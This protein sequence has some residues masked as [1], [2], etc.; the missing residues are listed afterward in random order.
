MEFAF[1]ARG[2]KGREKA[3]QRFFEILPG[4]TSWSILAGMVW[5]SFRD[6][7]TAAIVIIAFDFHWLLR[8]LYTTLFLVLAYVRLAIERHTDWLLRIKG[9]DDLARSAPPAL[10]PD[11]G[12][13]ERLSARAH[14]NQLERLKR[15]GPPPP[16]SRAVHHLV[17]FP[18][19]NEAREILEPGVRSVV[20]QKFPLK[21]VMLVVAL[22]A[23][24]TADVKAGVYA[25][26]EQ[27]GKFLDFQVIEHPDGLP[28]EARVKGA[29]A[30]FAARRAA[31]LFDAKGVPYENVVAS[32]LDAD[33][34]VSPDYFSCLTYH[35]LV[36]PDRTRASYQPI[37]VYHNNIWD[38][39][40]FARVMEMG[41]SFFQLMEATNPEK[42]VT[43]SSHSMSFKALV[44]TGYWPVDMI[45]DD[46]AIFW[47]AY[48]KFDGKY[49]VV[50]MYVTLSM[51]VVAADT[52]WQTFRNV[53]KQKRRWAWGVEN[54]PILMRG[55]LKNP[56]ISTYD[57]LKHGL[58][59]FEGHVA[60]A[61]WAFILTFIGWLP[62]LFAG[63]EFSSSV[64]YYSAPR[65]TGI[66]FNL[67]LFS[68]LTTIMLSLFLLPDKKMKH[69]FL[70]R[71]VFA[72]EWL[73]VPVIATFL[74]ALPALDTQTR[75]MTARY[76]ESF[77]VT[78]KKRK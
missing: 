16:P 14:R 47:K 10:A 5:L 46:S 76:M 24:A 62:G 72:L 54:F 36:T 3:L 17:I 38:V 66:I 11:A 67:A 43:F 68:L 45:S 26:K 27:Y 6:P 58:K 70:T 60:W 4:A 56:R 1:T 74:S 39:P 13:K 8:I 15:Y 69:P 20:F 23:R 9:L 75:F 49:R 59:L 61:T 30:T 55:F 35:F 29:N 19:A 48:L 71:A 57:K 33:T 40:G 50:P 78:E 53:Y 34:V 25:L 22:E 64:L 7:L 31:E 52:W 51:D 65:I 32:C 2:L 42:L 77:W 18:V 41:S 73:L 12:W 63:S 21:N 28:G 44:D 37:P